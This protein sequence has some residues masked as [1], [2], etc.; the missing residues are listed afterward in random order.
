MTSLQPDFNFLILNSS[1]DVI[2]WNFY[3]PFQEF[4]ENLE[5][6]IHPSQWNWTTPESWASIWEA[7]KSLNEKNSFL[8]ASYQNQ[9]KN[10]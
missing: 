3:Q 9:K 4:R 10:L 2:T 5:N 6:Q 7:A 8:K 1:G